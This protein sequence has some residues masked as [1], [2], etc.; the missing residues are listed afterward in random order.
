MLRLPLV[1]VAFLTRIPVGRLVAAG[2]DDV[3]RAAPLFPVVG[4]AVGAAAGL[5]ADVL[6]GPL[7]AQAAGALAVGV[8]ALATGAMHLDALAD[9]AD[10]LGASSRERALEILRDHA[11][12]AF[13]ATALVVVLLVDSAAFAGLAGAGDAALVGLAAGAAGR[14]VTL[15]LAAALPNARPGGGQ[16]L[17]LA[18]L[19]PWQVSLGV[20]LALC[21]AVPAGG[22][23]LAAVAAAAGAGVLLGLFYRRWLGGVTG[24]L[25]GAAAKVAETA[26]LVAALAV[27]R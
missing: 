3:A 21:L 16:G 10:A 11:I 23:G 4:A 2:P 8:A 19:R 22:A 20:A 5:T 24:D 25:L 9:T 7:P 26:A 14:A 27:V 12:G 15:P 6:T 13:G 18:G 1:A 17:V